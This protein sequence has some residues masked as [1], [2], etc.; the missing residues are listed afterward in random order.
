MTTQAV[1][2]PLIETLLALFAA[3]L[4]GLLV[5]VRGNLTALRSHVWFRR[6]LTWGGIVTLC[7]GALWLGGVIAVA[8]AALIA[9]QAVREAATLLSLDTRNRR[10]LLVA[11]PAAMVVVALRVSALPWLPPAFGVVALLV[12]LVAAALF[13]RRAPRCASASMATVG[14]TVAAYVWVVWPV[15]TAVVLGMQPNGVAWLVALCVMVG[16]TDVAA[17]VVGSRVGGPKLAPTVSPG[18]TWSGLAGSVAGAYLAWGLLAP[19]RPPVPASAALGLP[20]LVALLGTAGDLLESW[21]KRRA[22]VKDAGAWLP[23]FGG[24]LDRIDSALAVVPAVCW[25]LRLWGV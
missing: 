20:L 15:A 14:R 7:V 13:P 10:L 22:G 11:A 4:A 8:L 19:L 18:K 23:G 12:A 9:W 24:L 3:A 25:L 5:M 17:C 6:W 1:L 21:V 2:A 16:L